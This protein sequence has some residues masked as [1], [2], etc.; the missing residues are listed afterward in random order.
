MLIGISGMAKK[1]TILVLFGGKSVE[2]E[3]SVKSARNIVQALDRNKY[4]VVLVGVT[5]TGAWVPCN[6]PQLLSGNTTFLSEQA[7]A[8][9]SIT[10][11]NGSGELAMRDGG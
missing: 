4:D 10:P 7:E 3:V 8:K 11:Y 9:G 5:P 2:H 6:E 1:R